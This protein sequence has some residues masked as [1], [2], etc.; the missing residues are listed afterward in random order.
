M[1][2]S[3]FA[4]V[5]SGIQTVNAAITGVTSAPTEQP[6]SINTADLPLVLVDVAT[7]AS[8]RPAAGLKR[9]VT[10]YAIKCFVQPLA[11]GE[12][13]DEGYQ[14]KL[15]L[16][17]RFH[18]QYLDQMTGGNL[19]GETVEQ[20]V[21]PFVSESDRPLEMAGTLYHGFVIYVKV[22]EK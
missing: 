8:D 2:I 21:P 10:T 6:A 1:A 20:L 5:I 15:A 22:V 13:I 18:D 7:C 4:T 9:R 12:G 14:D 3:T 16:L 11:Q 19:F 17:G